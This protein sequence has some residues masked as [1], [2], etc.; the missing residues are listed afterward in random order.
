MLAEKIITV[1]GA[2]SGIGKA[3]AAL[4]AAQGARVVGLCRSVEKL[5]EGITGV[6]CDLTDAESISQAV[7]EV[8]V[9]FGRVDALVNNAGVAYLS[10]IMDGDLADWDTM[11][12]VNVR[13]LALMSQLVLPLMPERG[14]QIVNVSSMSGHRVP[15]TGGFYAPT[16]F[17][18]RAITESLRSELK[19]AGSA[20]RVSSVSPG[21]VDTP[22]LND[23]FAGRED[24]LQKTRA[25]MKMLSDEDIAQSIL[26]ILTTPLHVEV[27][28]IQLR[29]VDQGV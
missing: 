27:G 3:T 9:K 14:G 19:L 7:E 16:K 6:C 10:R 23:Y 17:A 26:H 21:F 2:S 20:T 8:R 13:G 11:W 22:L 29:S 25:A 1:T 12:K 4:C 15:P 28:D 18:V 24:A 5:S